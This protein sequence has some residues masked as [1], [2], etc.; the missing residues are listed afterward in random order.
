MNF[1]AS[2]VGEFQ[3]ALLAVGAAIATESTN[4]ESMSCS[5]CSGCDY[6][7][8]SGCGTNTCDEEEE[9]GEVDP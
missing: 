2:D 8:C 6:S 1:E 4:S 3:G 7:G 9:E 5:G